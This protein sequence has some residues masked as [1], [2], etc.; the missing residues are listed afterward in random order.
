ML[1]RDQ[2]KMIDGEPIF[3]GAIDYAILGNKEGCNRLL[4]KAFD[5][6]Y[7]NYPTMLT[8]PNLKSMQADPEFQQILNQA[9]TIHEAFKTK[10]F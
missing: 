1:I 7:F 6:G 9:K 5:A 10:F 3:Y 8:N 2:A 4:Q